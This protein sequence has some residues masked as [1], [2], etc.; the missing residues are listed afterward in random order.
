MEQKPNRYIYVI[1]VPVWN[2]PKLQTLKIKLW[3]ITKSKKQVIVLGWF[4]NKADNKSIIYLHELYEC[5]KLEGWALMSIPNPQGLS[6]IDIVTVVQCLFQFV[7]PNEVK[8]LGALVSLYYP[9]Y[10]QNNLE[11]WEISKGKRR[12]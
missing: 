10:L 11:N 6:N 12:N 5:S 4:N 1:K 3:K 7:P 8:L 9:V 2:F